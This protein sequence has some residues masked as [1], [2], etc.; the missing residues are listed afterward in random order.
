[1]TGQPAVR[2][3]ER[4]DRFICKGCGREF[5]FASSLVR[6]VDAHRAMCRGCEEA[7]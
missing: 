6:H 5:L 2:V 7:A 3:A 1:M 4:V